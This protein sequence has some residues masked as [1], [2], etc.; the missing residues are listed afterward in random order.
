[1]F[2]PFVGSCCCRVECPAA[3]TRPRPDPDPDPDPALRRPATS[4]PAVRN[5]D[6][7]ALVA[8]S[9]RG[10]VTRGRGARAAPAERLIIK[11]C[12]SPPSCNNMVRLL[13]AMALSISLVLRSISSFSLNRRAHYRENGKGGDILRMGRRV[14]FSQSALAESTTYHPLSSN[15]RETPTVLF[16][17]ETTQQERRKGKGK[18][19]K[20]CA[21]FLI[22]GKIATTVFI[23]PS[24]SARSPTLHSYVLSTSCF[25][26]FS[27]SFPSFSSPKIC[28]L[29]LKKTCE[30][31]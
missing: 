15:V 28:I 12:S 19:P 23:N 14:V 31:Q 20:K 7:P 24:A 16:E 3:A 18:D 8:E 9:C 27:A 22:V 30:G 1:M 13:W 17:T 26:P 21:P 5:R 2:L 25:S 6:D 4:W 29:L 10:R 11:S